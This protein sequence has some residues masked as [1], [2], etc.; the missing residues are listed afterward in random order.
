[1]LGG[2]TACLHDTQPE[3]MTVA[4]V[5]YKFAGAADS[6]KRMVSLSTVIE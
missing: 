6:V 4:V 2:G 5:I 3:K 1:M